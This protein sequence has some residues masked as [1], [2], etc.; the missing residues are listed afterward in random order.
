MSSICEDIAE[1][2][3]AAKIKCQFSVFDP[4]ISKQ[5][6]RDAEYRF[7]EFECRYDLGDLMNSVKDI[8]SMHELGNTSA[9]AQGDANKDESPDSP[10]VSE[11]KATHQR[12]IITAPPRTLASHPDKEEVL[13]HVLDKA[14]GDK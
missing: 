7:S 13:I 8:S 14:F 6:Q 4:F 9:T 3:K 2:Q 1:K 11:T 12:R 5:D 10:Y